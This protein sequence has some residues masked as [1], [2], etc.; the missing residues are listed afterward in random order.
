MQDRN[1]RPSRRA[2]IAGAL[3]AVSAPAIIRGAAAQQAVPVS[4]RLAELYEK[5]KPEGE[6][7]IWA[8]GA[9]GV[10]W[11]PAEF[12]KRF[13]AVKVNWLGDQQASSKMIAEK[14]AGRHVV[15]VWT[16][17]LGGTLEVQKR[18]LL[19]KFDWRPYGAQERDI[20]WD[21]EAVTNHNFVYA[22]I[23]AKSKLAKEQVPRRW[24][25]LLDPQWTDKLISDSFLLP[26]LGGY[27]AIDW[28]LER[29][30]KWI[31]ALIDQRKLLVTTS[32]VANFLKTGER[33]L[34]VAE[35]TGGAFLMNKD[36]LN[37]GYQVMEVVPATQ[38]VLGAVKQAP[39]PNA[40]RL[41][42]A[43]LIS[44]EAKMLYE[45]VAG[46]PDIRANSA[47]PLAKEIKA[48]GAKVI[49]EDVETM[50]QRAEY[51]RKLMSIVRGQ[52]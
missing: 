4:P 42:V 22:P 36:G 10:Q 45:E 8:P 27:L 19:E 7:M 11:I 26:R 9:P 1:S 48:A 23:F 39:H 35:S 38:F 34:A 13:P 24:D 37:V 17:S 49:Y 16:Y 25:D 30:E 31:K 18:G 2:V 6:V 33:Q 46:Q 14:R 29:T 20:F 21:G 41:L 50:N 5:A 3:A 43:W 44:P 15:D 47:S 32:P 51:Y 40:A 52:G 28:G 12:A